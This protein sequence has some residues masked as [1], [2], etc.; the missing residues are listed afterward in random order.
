V[1][2][3]PG[4]RLVLASAN[5]D[6]AAE[7]AAV[8]SS[9]LEVELVPRPPGTPE[10]VEDG[11]TLLDNARLK[12]VALVAATGLPSVADDT[13]LE[14]DALGG[15]PGVYSARYAGERATYADNVAKLLAE[16]AAGPG[17][18]GDRRARFRT[19]ALAAF[20]G[21]AEYWSEG[22]VEGHIAEAPR[23]TAGFG[24]DPVFVPAEG[25]GRTFAEMSPEEKHDI[26]HR[27]RA[28]RTLAALLSKN[29]TG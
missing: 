19:V 23:G 1:S 6:K 22:T 28:F 18:G 27:G 24:Y 7:I 10:V 17:A 29:V 9:A 13:G 5:P 16:L 4:L 15:A 11:E 25:D 26:S 20:P 2:A 12:A 14:V 8:L 3:G 21:G